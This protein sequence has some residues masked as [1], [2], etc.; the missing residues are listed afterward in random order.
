MK[1]DKLGIG[2]IGC[3]TIA[4]RM[5]KAWHPHMRNARLVAASDINGGRVEHFKERFGVE[6]GYAEE[7]ALLND[8]DVDA[9]F[10]LTPNFL[11]APQTI[12]AARA[13]KHVLCQKPLA[14]TTDEA[15]RM[16]DAAKENN[17]TL[18]AAF[19]KRFWPYYAAVRKLIDDGALGR[20]VSI[21][22]QFSHS[23]I[24]KYYVP[25]SNWFND[26]AKAGG[27]PLADLGVHHFDVM[28]WLVGAEVD[29]VSAE[30]TNSNGVSDALEDNAIVNLGFAN[31]VVGQGYYS[32]TTV[33]PPGVTL[34]RLEVYGTVG[35]VIVTLSHPG[36]VVVQYCT[37]TGPLANLGWV[38]LPVTEPVPAF[39]LM[40]QH[41]VD[42]IREG[43]Q[44][45]TV[46]EDGL[47]T[48]E[49]AEHAYISAKEGRRVS[50]RD[51]SGAKAVA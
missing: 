6:R 27:G 28:R 36:R 44:P 24:G 47:R 11:H 42:C 49:I 10:V 25:A 4:E 17:V 38:D 2:I 26:R 46:G 37:E 32:F 14:L 30:M 40:L 35:S 22:T 5:I 18:M 23:G 13:G 50:M 1:S 29:Y 45:V 33:A 51:H 12:A 31:G 9:V 43:R 16:I 15:S 48:V 19:V 7:S 20:V 3:G 41:F 34:E 8:P 39:G 21:R